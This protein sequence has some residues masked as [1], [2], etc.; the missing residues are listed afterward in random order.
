MVFV[1]E[2][3]RCSISSTEIFIVWGSI[4]AN[5]GTAP[6][7]KRGRFVAVQVRTGVITSSPRKYAKRLIDYHNLNIPIYASYHDTKKHKPDPEPFLYA[8]D[9]LN[10]NGIFDPILNFGDSDID[11]VAANKANKKLAEKM[12]NNE[13]GKGWGIYNV[14]VTTGKFNGKQLFESGASAVLKD[15]LSFQKFIDSEESKIQVRWFYDKK[16][17]AIIESFLFLNADQFLKSQIDKQSNDWL[18]N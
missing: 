2:V 9:K 4:S 5:I 18:F 10:I 12:P 1:L 6:I 14:G 3:I 16:Y 17:S 8:I 7:Y 11:M 15:F 13:L